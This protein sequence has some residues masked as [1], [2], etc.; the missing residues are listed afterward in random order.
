VKQQTVSIDTFHRSCAGFAM[1]IALASCVIDSDEVGPDA[2]PVGEI[3]SSESDLGLWTGVKRP[4][5][6]ASTMA[7]SRRVLELKPQ[8]SGEITLSASLRWSDLTSS[9]I[10][11]QVSVALVSDVSESTLLQVFESGGLLRARADLAMT[12]VLEPNVWYRVVLTIA[13]APNRL[14]QVRVFDAAGEVWRSCGDG[15]TRCPS[16]QIDAD[17]L[18]SLRLSVVVDDAREGGQVE[19][20]N[21]SLDKH[22]P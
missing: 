5:Y 4:P 9:A 10:S 18:A 8:S 1:A 17:E 13:D 20:Q 22:N 19:L 21:V 7:P 16:V 12:D 6:A 15:S 14:M 3:V 2:Q 11:P